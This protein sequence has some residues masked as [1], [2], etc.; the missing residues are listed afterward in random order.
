MSTYQII[1]FEIN[2]MELTGRSRN[3]QKRQKDVVM[4]YLSWLP[5]KGDIKNAKL[6]NTTK[7]INIILTKSQNQV[8][9]NPLKRR[10]L[11]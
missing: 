9:M 4:R 2:I 10:R 6:N 3:N 5:I 7:K 1:I 8:S 11:R